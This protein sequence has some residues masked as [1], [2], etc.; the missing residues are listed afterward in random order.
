M[1][2]SKRLSKGY[3]RWIYASSRWYSSNSIDTPYVDGLS[4]THG[5]PCQHIWTYVV[6][7]NDYGGYDNEHCPCA[8]S[9]GVDPPS[10]VGSNYYCESGSGDTSHVAIVQDITNL[11]DNIY[12]SKIHN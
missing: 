7:H 1:W 4:I 5:T 6:G 3:N 8:Q 12:F 2:E 10:F 11:H 9:P